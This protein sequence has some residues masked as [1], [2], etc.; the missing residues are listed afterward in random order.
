ML[1]GPTAA[2]HIL[3]TPLLLL[4]Q[5]GQVIKIDKVFAVWHI[6]DLSHQYPFQGITIIHLHLLLV[7]KI[8]PE[9]TSIKF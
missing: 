8:A 7:K 2:N 4:V 1:R 3:D 6:S 5:G 9:V